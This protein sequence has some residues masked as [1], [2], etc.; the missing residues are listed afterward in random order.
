M[1]NGAYGEKER[2]KKCG[3]VCHCSDDAENQYVW[4]TLIYV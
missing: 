4:Y 1:Y 3:F 2:E